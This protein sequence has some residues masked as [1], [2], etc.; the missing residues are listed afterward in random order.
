M[1]N[2]GKIITNCGLDS[3]YPGLAYMQ[4]EFTWTAQKI[5]PGK[6]RIDYKSRPCSNDEKQSRNTY[7]FFRV[8]YVDEYDETRYLANY[9][10]K[11]YSFSYN[12]AYS[13][14]GYI[15][16]EHGDK[17]EANFNVTYEGRIYKGSGEIPQESGEVSW[18]LDDNFNYGNCYWQSESIEIQVNGKQQNFLL[19]NTEF[20][21][22]WEGAQPGDNNKISGYKVSYTVGDWSSPVVEVDENTTSYVFSNP[23][24]EKQRGQ[25]VSPYVEII[26]QRE[27]YVTNALQGGLAA[28]VNQKPLPPKISYINE[29]N[30]QQE[31]ST[32]L[33]AL[34]SN[35]GKEV[36]SIIG[37]VVEQSSDKELEIRYKKSDE[38]DWSPMV[39]LSIEPSTTLVSYSFCVNDGYENSDIIEIKFRRNSAEVPVVSYQQNSS[40]PYELILRAKKDFVFDDYSCLFQLVL[41]KE[42]KIVLGEYKAKYDGNIYECEISDIRSLISSRYEEDFNFD[43]NDTKLYIKAIVVDEWNDENFVG[44]LDKPIDFAHYIVNDFKLSFGDIQTLNDKKC[45]KNQISFSFT[46]PEGF[47]D[48]YNAMCIYVYDFNK[49]PSEI[50]LVDMKWNENQNSWYGYWSREQSKSNVQIFDLGFYLYNNKTQTMSY[51]YV[52]NDNFYQVIKVTNENLSNFTTGHNEFMPLRKFTNEGNVDSSVLY[53]CSIRPEV[54]SAVIGMEEENWYGYDY[55]FDFNKTKPELNFVLE[56]GSVY[57][58]DTQIPYKS[59]QLVRDL[60]FYSDDIFHSM[61]DKINDF[62]GKQIKCTL[63]LKLTDVFG[64]THERKIED[65]KIINFQQAPYVGLQILIKTGESSYKEL[66]ESDQIKQSTTLLF[67]GTIKSY[68]ANPEIELQ[69]DKQSFLTKQIELGEIDTEPTYSSPDKAYYTINCNFE[70]KIEPIIADISSK[71]AILLVDNYNVN[72]YKYE[73]VTLKRH[74]IPIVAL[75]SISCDGE[76][77]QGTFQIQDWGFD[78]GLLRYNNENNTDIKLSHNEKDSFF[79]YSIDNIKLYSPTTGNTIDITSDDYEILEDGKNPIIKFIV[80]KS[81]EER[82]DFFKQQSSGMILEYLSAGISCQIHL[83]INFGD[84]TDYTLDKESVITKI[85]YNLTPTVSYRKNH[86][87]INTNQIDSAQQ[88]DI[89]VIVNQ[90]NDRKNILFSGLNNSNQK[91]Q[92][93]LDLSTMGL[94]GFVVDCGSWSGVPG[95]IVPNPD[96]PDG[97]AQIAYTGQIYDLQQAEDYEVVLEAGG[98]PI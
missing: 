50:H 72:T 4:W 67:W 71:S 7:G 59:D 56:D 49:I 91:T 27:G 11:S 35:Y 43:L 24:T 37:D 89:V 64:E 66:S 81:T 79:S 5:S 42:Y 55:G 52:C 74:Q 85:V 28:Y 10:N 78:T 21:I 9:T 53:S 16:I 31:I 73:N 12:P 26:P 82:G 6:T 57:T 97:L 19:P 48:S 93:V 75:Q 44:E 33:L 47:K 54:N 13:Q 96:A 1:A 95:G 23:L 8:K 61:K 51:D 17:G 87:G 70:H 68:K 94:L 84:N 98:A 83:S 29:K 40:N 65:T 34:T 69:I 18:Q 60:K 20:T 41:E 62:I 3:S 15:I 46:P 32:E 80:K 22:V 86:I 38:T 88:E 36:L 2:Q 30:V 45:F 92:G 58:I 63:K 25:K 77:I 90:Y 39:S 76:F 14:S